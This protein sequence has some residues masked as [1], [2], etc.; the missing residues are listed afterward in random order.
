MAK[1]DYTSFISGSLTISNPTFY[2]PTRTDGAYYYQA[3]RVFINSAGTY[4]FVSNSSFD[5]FGYLYSPTFDPA[6]PNSN[7]I[8]YD[9]D[10]G[11]NSQFRIN[12]YLQYGTYILV[13]TTYAAG[14]RGSFG[15]R[16]IG[17]NSVDLMAY[18]PSVI[19]SSTTRK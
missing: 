3:F 2:R 16:V 4:A 15:L 19:V 9:D 7:V 13:V 12:E 17:T 18:T 6:Y 5:T 10:S 14:Q 1:S 8:A 11:G